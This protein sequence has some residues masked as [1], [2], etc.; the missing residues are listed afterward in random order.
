M[1]A[2]RG[3]GGPNNE[4]AARSLLCAFCALEW[5]VS[6]I[7]CVACGEEDP[8]KLPNY[9]APGHEEARIE[10]CETCRGYVKCIDLTN[11]ARLLPEVDDL[12]SISLDLW[13]VEQGFQRIEPGLAGI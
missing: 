10:A 9:S 8:A 2:R 3:G 1:S 4:G 6:R 12:A 11:D 13:A 5:P 7:R